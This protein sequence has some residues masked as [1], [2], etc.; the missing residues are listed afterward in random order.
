MTTQHIVG[1]THKLKPRLLFTLSYITHKQ[2]PLLDPYLFYVISSD[3]H[4]KQELC[5]TVLETVYNSNQLIYKQTESDRRLE[6]WKKE[7]EA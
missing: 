1:V 4:L 7:Q 3:F 5:L 2:V 6:R